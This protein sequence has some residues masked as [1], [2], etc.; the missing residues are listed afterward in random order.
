MTFSPP[1]AAALVSANVPELVARDEGA[2]TL[3]KRSEAPHVAR[4]ETSVVGR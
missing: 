4:G 2:A 3:F 1:Q